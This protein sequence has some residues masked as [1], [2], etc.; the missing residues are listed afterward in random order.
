M[1]EA[2]ASVLVALLYK[3]D[4]DGME[5]FFTSSSEPVGTF[6]L[7]QQ[8]YEEIT[9]MRP[10]SSDE[11]TQSITVESQAATSSPT[12]DHVDEDIRSET[13]SNSS[14]G[15]DIDIRD[16]LGHILGPS[17]RAKYN[18]K[19]TVLILTD[20]VWNGIPKRK[21]ADK[22]AALLDRWLE[23]S[24]SESKLRKRK[25]SVQFIHFGDN[26]EAEEELKR[27]DN[28]LTDKQGNVL[29]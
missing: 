21:V 27:M 1:V 8:F 15:P 14:G 19:L 20:G 9:R 4:S 28:N 24:K 17:G 2:L 18:R 11:Q 3:Q 5:L 16:V 29:P 7:P 22:L 25:L 12:R 13:S 6:T 23:K 26:P 10:V